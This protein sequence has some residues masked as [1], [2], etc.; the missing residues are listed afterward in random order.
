MTVPESPRVPVGSARGCRAGC[1][2]LSTL[3][4]PVHGSWGTRSW[5][6]PILG[7]WGC[8]KPR[9]GWGGLSSCL[10]AMLWG[11]FLVLGHSQRVLGGFGELLGALAAGSKAEGAQSTRLLGTE[12]TLGTQS[13]RCRAMP[14]RTVPC[15]SVP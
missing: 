5:G 2:F 8:L 11:W 3:G 9:A 13:A 15:C 10:G 14:C 6:A 12:H 7:I 1:P 4:C